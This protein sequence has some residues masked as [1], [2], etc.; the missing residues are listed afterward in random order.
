M[1]YQNNLSWITRMINITMNE[2]KN[3]V[4]KKFTHLQSTLPTSSQRRGAFLHWAELDLHNESLQLQNQETVSMYYQ[5]ESITM[6]LD[7]ILHHNIVFSPI[8]ESPFSMRLIT[9]LYIK[10]SHGNEEMNPQLVICNS[11]NT[12]VT[13]NNFGTNRNSKYGKYPL[14]E[15]HVYHKPWIF[16]EI[17]LQF[18]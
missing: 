5:N 15:P 10:L 16:L 18:R 12:V 2:S 7:Q 3:Y 1:I 11:W 4:I 6:D 14:K 13:A 9:Y 8:P 17:S